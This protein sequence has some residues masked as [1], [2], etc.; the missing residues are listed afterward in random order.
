MSNGRTETADA[1]HARL[2]TRV[3]QQFDGLVAAVTIPF[4][5]L[6]QCTVAADAAESNDLVSI[7]DTA[8][9]VLAALVQDRPLHPSDRDRLTSTG[10][11]SATLGL[12]ERTLVAAVSEAMGAGLDFVLLQADETEGRA[13]VA[14]VTSV[15][16]AVVDR[17]GRVKAEVIAA[18]M[19]G[20]DQQRSISGENLRDSAT[21]V[22]RLVRGRWSDEN[23]IRQE[24][25]ACGLDLSR[26]FAL[27]LF[28][29]AH[30][31]M[32]L[33]EV[34]AAVA[35]FIARQ[36]GAV[37]GIART[38]PTLPH[39]AVLVAARSERSWTKVVRTADGIARDS[40]FHVF[41][42]EPLNPLEALPT[43][44]RR[45]VTDLALPAAAALSPGALTADQ[46]AFHRVYTAASVEDRVDFVDRTIGRLLEDDFADGLIETIETLYLTGGGAAQVGAAL[47]RHE[48]SVRGR[49]DKITQLTG[50]DVAKPEDL[51]Q[52]YLAIRLRRVVQKNPVRG[53]QPARPKREARRNRR[54]DR[55]AP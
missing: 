7:R 53:H 29:A 9:A 45:A 55:E 1:Y 18:L 25:K 49:F 54:G 2:F 23:E 52:L 3:T 21:V 32:R 47:N 30:A 20:H 4:V 50:R 43:Q 46:L 37:S 13:S 11:R 12:R 39:A 19:E 35:E 26:T 51:E 42:Y 41:C 8:A 22:D 33:D 14:Y 6:P 34:Q 38:G 16:R 31:D 28:A 40:G 17:H 24:A 27:L 5:R 44:Y 36:R 10:A 15:L 48:N